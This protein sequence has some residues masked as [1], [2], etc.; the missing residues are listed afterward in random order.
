[1]RLSKN[2]IAFIKHNQQAFEVL[3]V[4]HTNTHEVPAAEQGQSMDNAMS[5]I[6]AAPFMQ[7]L[8]GKESLTI[9]TVAHGV[10]DL[11]Q[12]HIVST[13]PDRRTYSQWVIYLTTDRDTHYNLLRV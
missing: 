2:K 11:I 6:E 5:I 7:S 9:N 4:I 3:S 13:S 12:I 8:G 1:M 10:Q